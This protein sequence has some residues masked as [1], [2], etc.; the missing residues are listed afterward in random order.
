MNDLIRL[1]VS[2]SEYDMVDIKKQFQELY[3]T[4]LEE[5]I[6]AHCSGICKDVL[7]ALVR[8]TNDDL[9]RKPSLLCTCTHKLQ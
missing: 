6:K 8:G 9:L 4:S 7:V 5:M 2:R 3:K 1:I